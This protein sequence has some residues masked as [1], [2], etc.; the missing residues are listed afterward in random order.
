MK[1]S[2]TNECLDVASDNVHRVHLIV[3][4]GFK[5]MEAAGA[6]SVFSYAN[7]RLAARGETFHYHVS[8]VAPRPGPV[9]SDIHVCLEA[10]GTLPETEA[11]ETVVVVG[12][13]NIERAL[14]HE[15]SLVA[16]CRQRSGDAQ[17]FAALCTGSFF[18]AEAGLLDQRQTATHWRFAPLLQARYPTLKVDADAIFV[19]DGHFWTSAGVTA[20]ID[21]ALAFVEQDLGRDLAL[22]V[23]RDLVVYLKRL[24]GQSQFS[25][26]LTSQMTGSPSMRALQHWIGERLDQP[27]TLADMANKAGMSP[28][29]F[30]RTFMAE[31]GMTPTT[32]LE[33]A[34]CERAKALLLDT[35]LPMKSI[36]WRTGFSSSERMRKVFSRRYTLTPTAYRARF[37][38]TRDEPQADA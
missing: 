32:W 17:R 9:T 22:D 18:L 12:A 27:L 5:F 25:A 33:N 36:A 35:K 10:E 37:K 19:Q 23:A 2:E 7:E 16:W 4:P 13:V 30:S 20:A 31:L 3:Y 24:G 28:R 8:L 14:E 38:T 26:A 11:L 1:N 34:R 15:R 6:L 29:H 21:L